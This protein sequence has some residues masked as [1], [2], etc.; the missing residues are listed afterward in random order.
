MVAGRSAIGDTALL[1]G[2]AVVARVRMV[3]VLMKVVKALDDFTCKSHGKGRGMRMGAWDE[4]GDADKGGWVGGS[5]EQERS[6][7]D[8]M[9]VR[10][11]SSIF[12]SFPSI[13]FSDAPCACNVTA[14]PKP[15]EKK[16]LPDATAYVHFSRSLQTS[17]FNHNGIIACL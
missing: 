10:L 13:P 17:C 9:T 3:V 16:S 11:L 1:I 14:G 5:N 4:D 7:D 12:F 6:D 8:E 15:S 2:G